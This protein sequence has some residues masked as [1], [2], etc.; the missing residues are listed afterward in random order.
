MYKFDHKIN[1]LLLFIYDTT[2]DDWL[3][4]IKNQPKSWPC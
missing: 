1:A 4:A 2:M 3:Y